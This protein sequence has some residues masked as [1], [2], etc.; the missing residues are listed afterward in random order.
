[1]D[2]VFILLLLSLFLLISCTQKKSPINEDYTAALK[3]MELFLIQE[4]ELGNAD[5][6]V[7][8]AKMYINIKDYKTAFKWYTLA[9]EQ[10]HISAQ[11]RLGNMYFKGNGV[12]QDYVTAH[13]WINIVTSRDNSA[14]KARDAIEKKMTAAQVA[15]AQK[16]ARE[17]VAKNYNG[18]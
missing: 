6:Q 8:L 5:A 2:R 14:Q 1:M 10:G 18:C 9:A 12:V 16:L 11:L 7:S 4:A 13:M 17:C 15:E 3:D